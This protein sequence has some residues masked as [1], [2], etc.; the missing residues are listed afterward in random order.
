MASPPEQFAQTRLLFEHGHLAASQDVAGEW[1]ERYRSVNPEWATRFRI[2]EAE[3]AAWRGRSREVVRILDPALPPSADDDDRV[4]RLSLL[5]A[6]QIHLRRGGEAAQSLAAADALCASMDRPVCGHVLNAHATLEARRGDNA[7]AYGF[8]LRELSVARNFQDRFEEAAAL[9]NLAGTCLRE[10]HFDEAIDWLNASDRAAEPLGAED[11]LL[12]NAGNLGWAY[13]SLGDRERA[14][15]LFQN[16]ESRAVALGDTDDTINWLTTSGYVYQDDHNWLQAEAAYRQALQIA[17][18][19]GSSVEIV[20]CLEDLAHASIQL[21][22]L[23]QAD[24]YLRQL[25]PLVA[26][27]GNRLDV[28]DVTLA[29][30]RIAAARGQEQQA[31]ALLRQVET[32]QSSQITMRLGAEHELARLFE[33]EGR[34]GDALK[35][36][37]AALATFESARAEIQ[38]E[39]SKL[40][41]FANAT[42]IYDD[43]IRLLI[44]QGKTE[45]ALAAADQS[46]ARTLAQGL[47]LSPAHPSLHPASFHPGAIAARAGATLLFYWLGER[48]SWLWVITRAKTAV[49]QL[50]PEAEIARRVARYRQALQ[51]P[52]DPIAPANEDGLGLYRILVAPAQQWLPSGGNVDILCDGALSA[53]NFETL[54]VSQSSPHYWIED[55]NIVSA[56]SLLL[57]ASSQPAESGPLNLLLIGN[58]TSPGPD[59]PELA[60]AG[61]EMRQIRRHFS[62]QRET[63]FEGQQATPRSYLQSAPQRFTYIDFVAHG[64]ASRTDPMDSAI[65]L[66][67]MQGNGDSFRLHARD[68]MHHP[69]HARLVTIAA[70]YGGG[71]RAFAGEGLVGL[72]WAFLYAGAHSVIGA[73]WEVSD[74]STPQL[75]DAVYQGI[76]DGLPPRTALHRAKL[77]LLHGR[78]QRPFFWASF[79]LYTGS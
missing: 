30:G 47:G 67:G 45:E 17:R 32:D 51:G 6:A 69:I 44:S 76:Q 9:M 66:S 35:M 33:S 78:F 65:I 58:A 22:E 46:R 2:L 60:N 28:L 27:S 26:A 40:P 39:D 56:P 61:F 12:E 20:N 62:P 3:S 55:A 50:P 77:L 79:Q 11:I 36:Y 52:E 43:Y 48:R 21:G 49:V 5:A 72:S 34:T 54:I 57:L 41:Y 64:V 24:A 71:M 18:A 25:D 10:E 38:N 73:L 74:A 15:A 1:A 23:S 19:I 70:C 63:I 53:L 59:Y 42:P 4:R 75:M 29:R 8:Y 16:A 13:Y 7:A 31:E 14:L 37:A 68:I